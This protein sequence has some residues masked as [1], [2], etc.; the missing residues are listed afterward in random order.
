MF[1]GVNAG[2]AVLAVDVLL[3]REAGR[4]PAGFGR[5]LAAVF[6]DCGIVRRGRRWPRELDAAPD[7]IPAEPSWPGEEA[8]H[9][10]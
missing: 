7:R 9:C 8:L 2:M 1:A 6:A 10:V 3:R 5:T 4:C